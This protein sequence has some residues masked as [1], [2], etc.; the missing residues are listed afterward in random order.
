MSMTDVD[1]GALPPEPPP[2]ADPGG[3]PVGTTS[4]PP[5]NVG[6]V[7]RT[8]APA[9]PSGVDLD[10]LSREAAAIQRD[11]SAA[12]DR[13]NAEN[14]ARLE[15][16]RARL[17]QQYNAA[18]IGPDDLK[19]WDA[20]AARE[21]FRHDP[22]EEFGS[23]GSVFAIIASAFTNRPMENAFLG[24]AAAINAAKEGKQ[25][26]FDRAYKAWQ[27]NTKLALERQ[28]IQSQQF[29]NA[30]TLFNTDMTLGQERAKLLATQYGDKQMALL[31]DNGLYKEAIDLNEKR[32]TA[33]LKL[34]ET[35]PKIAIDN[36]KM[37]DLLSRG[38]D[39]RNPS[40]PESQRAITAWRQDWTGQ[41]YDDDVD[42]ARRWWEENPRGTS[43][44]FSIAFGEHTQRKLNALRGGS[45][46]QPKPEEEAVRDLAKTI[47]AEAEAK[48]EK[49]SDGEALTRATRQY[50]L[51][52]AAPT[53]NRLDDIAGDIDQ[54]NNARTA[55]QKNIE[56]LENYA[57]GAGIGGQATR[58]AERIGNI[59]GSDETAR[60]E[61]QKRIAYMK[62]IAPRLLTM[63]RG[64][65]LAAEAA[66]VNA[67]I[68]GLGWGDTTANTLAAMRSFDELMTK[69]QAD[70]EK[71]RSVDPNRSS[72][73]SLP[74]APA[75][76]SAPW[77]SDPV[78]K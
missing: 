34:A 45:I 75:T 66:N 50:R 18:G 23:I 10:R 30:V 41:K 65:P 14:I 70:L 40:T 38:Y 7:V 27:D 51:Q 64:R 13:V 69:M 60:V 72:A 26:E 55:A 53:G 61:F 54:M 62:M 31:L 42:F 37:N 11:K 71:R 20:D 73:A 35:L 52:S 25:Q 36:Y 1:P 56:F 2:L 77:N 48:G 9:I 58:M 21:K 39:P 5:V 12:T 8:T 68:A 44:E 43:E 4:P 29:S 46:R 16:D 28:K 32:Q 17:E 49:I 78:A 67:V 6:E 19:P 47:K 24:S 33:A 59:F 57:F 3:V 15:R 22:I 63:S 76:K 74:A